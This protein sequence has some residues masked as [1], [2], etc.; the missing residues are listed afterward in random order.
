M[1]GGERSWDAAPPAPSREDERGVSVHY[2][3]TRPEED[4]EVDDSADS[5]Y[6]EYSGVDSRRA[7]ANNNNFGHDLSYYAQ[8]QGGTE[9]TRYTLDNGGYDRT[10]QMETLETEDDYFP[11]S[12]YSS[13]PVKPLNVKRTP[14][15]AYTTS[16][17]PSSSHSGPPKALAQF[18]RGAGA[19]INRNSSIDP[20]SSFAGPKKG[21]VHEGPAIGATGFRNPFG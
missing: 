16:S 21:K 10:S 2:E 17:L 8:P 6:S 14:P 12:H 5:S 7:S 1:K 9:E 19:A 11:T 20:F 18:N 13:P 15:L 4:S 3:P